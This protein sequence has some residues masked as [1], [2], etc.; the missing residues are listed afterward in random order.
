MNGHYIL[1]M[2]NSSLSNNVLTNHQH[3]FRGWYWYW[4]TENQRYW[5]DTAAINVVECLYDKLLAVSLPHLAAYLPYD[6]WLFS[7]TS[8]CTVNRFTDVRQRHGSKCSRDQEIPPK[9]KTAKV[10][11]VCRNADKQWWF[12]GFC[13]YRASSAP[14]TLKTISKRLITIRCPPKIQT[15]DI[16][17]TA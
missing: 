3:R 13:C 12:N 15:T 14:V 8:Q 2:F 6:A 16:A 10:I 17:T 11:A 4:G 1:G 7:C 5:N 9:K